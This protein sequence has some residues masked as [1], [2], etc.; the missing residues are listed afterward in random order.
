[1]GVLKKPFQFLFA[2]ALAIALLACGDSG[3]NAAGGANAEAFNP[4]SAQ[5]EDPALAD[6]YNRS[7]RSCH[8]TG[9]SQAPLTTDVEAWRPR[10]AKGMDT[11][12]DHTING[13]EGMPPMGMCFDCSEAQFEAL[14]LFMA[15]AQ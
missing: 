2:I 14:I 11:L 5:P 13:F 15:V 4:R 6:V 3:Q 12:L 8:A 1:M 7:C 10:M 9:A